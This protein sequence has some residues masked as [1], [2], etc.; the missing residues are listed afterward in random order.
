[1]GRYRILIVE[2]EPSM[3]ELLAIMLEKQGY[4]VEG[5]DTYQDAATKLR[6]GL[7]DLLITDLWLQDDRQGG[8]KVLR[9][10]RESDGFISSI[11]I[12]AHS[13]VDSAVEA[14][15]LGACDYLIKPFKNDELKLVVEKAIES[16]KL[17]VENKTLRCELKKM[18]R[19]DDLVGN[20]AVINSMKNLIRK[21]ACLSSTVLILGESGTGK[22]LVAKAIHNCSM[23]SDSPFVAINCGGMP[24][25]LLESELFGHVKGAFTG[26][27][28]HKDG[29]FKVANGGSLFLDEIGE[30]SMALQVKLLRVLDEM[31]IRPVGSAADFS[32]DVRLISATNKNLETMVNEGRFREDFFYRLN[33][34]PIYVPALRERRE[35][36]LLLTR[37]FLKKFCERVGR[38]IAITSDAEKI[39]EQYSWPGNVRELENVIE[40][41]AAL[42]NNDTITVDD[43]PAKLCNSAAEEPYASEF[44]PDGIDLNE[45]VEAFERSLIRQA[46]RRSG[47]SQTRAARL[48]R[49]SPRSLRYKLE[50]FNLKGREN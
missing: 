43:L 19:L 16:K 33:V 9:E 47:N 31:K 25:N 4:E 1:M 40:R 42:C 28:S 22:E 6:T 38:Q 46:M 17:R 45:R 21:V 15:K 39:L 34:I 48:L 37:H 24:E 23:R 35:D 20:S 13:S 44:N 30:T 12:T 32:V 11:V 7:W 27:V 41:A 3:R 50:K 10:A 2:D 36:I 18:G 5:V 49:L 8:I 29:L 26:A 14:M